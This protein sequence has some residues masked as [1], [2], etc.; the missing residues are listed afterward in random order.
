[1]V[2]P[3]SSPMGVL[4]LIVGFAMLA[5]AGYSTIQYRKYLRMVDQDYK[6]SPFDIH[7]ECAIGSLLCLFGCVSCAD[8]FEPIRMAQTFHSKTPDDMSYRPEFVT[9][10]HRGRA[11]GLL[12]SAAKSGGGSKDR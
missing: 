1:M 6:G 11:L 2:Q 7:I 12:L 4:L 8:D 9:F 3:K 10:N 5:H